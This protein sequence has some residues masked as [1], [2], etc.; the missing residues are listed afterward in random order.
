[1]AALTNKQKNRNVIQPLQKRKK[2][3]DHLQASDTVGLLNHTVQDPEIAQ[4]LS[5]ILRL[6]NHT[7]QNAET[8]QPLSTILRL[9][10]HTVHNT[11]IAQSYCPGR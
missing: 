5:T 3:G 7:V 8:A 6:L 1:M 10:N 9:L 4:P 11:E 2:Q